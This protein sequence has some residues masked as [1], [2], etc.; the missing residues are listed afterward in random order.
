M[1]SHRKKLTGMILMLAVFFS[2]TVFAQRNGEGFLTEVSAYDIF[3]QG[4]GAASLICALLSFQQKKRAHIMALQM[5]A[6][7]LFSLQLFLLGAVTGAC[8]DLISFIRTMIFASREKHKWAS[9]PVWLIGFLLAMIISG[10][11][12]WS[13]IYSLTAILG[14]CLSTIA[15]WMKDGSK[16]R[17]VSL[18]VGPCW[19][20]YNWIYGSVAGVL[21]EILAMTSIIIGILRL[22]R[23][24]AE[25]HIKMQE[26]S[27]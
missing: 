8:V 20:I 14:S 4:V 6:S 27:K 9:S 7:L 23:K 2:T 17:F 26:I 3:V 13:N 5:L 11:L 16:I 21:S 18:F 25:N 22:D 10:L 15:L 24:K 19:I 1:F 12:T